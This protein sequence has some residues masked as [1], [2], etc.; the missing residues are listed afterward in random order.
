MG[1]LIV[2]RGIPGSGKSTR[3]E[4]IVASLPNTVKVC[5]DDIRYTLFGKYVGLSR[6]E[7]N[8]VSE[9]EAHL[10]NTAIGKGQNVVID[11]MHLNPR[12][13]L[14][15]DELARNSD[16]E[17]IVAPVEIPI[18]V[19][20]ARDSRRSRVVGEDVIRQIAK[21]WL[22]PDGSIPEYVRKF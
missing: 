12:Y 11:A 3:G 9:C 20:I 19:A 7:E 15:W 6:A 10:V 18:S 22:K 1:T 8:R 21:R 16:Y 17:F 5:R 4:K 2:L 13:V 14:K